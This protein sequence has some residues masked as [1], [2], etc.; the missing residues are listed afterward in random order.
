MGAATPPVLISSQETGKTT[1]TA[2]LGMTVLLIQ[3][4]R[5]IRMRVLAHRRMPVH[6]FVG[7]VSRITLTVMRTVMTVMPITRGTTPGRAIRRDGI[8]RGGDEPIS[9]R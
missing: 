9:I 1:H 2:G 5:H 4:M 7:T 8:A 3:R 6:E